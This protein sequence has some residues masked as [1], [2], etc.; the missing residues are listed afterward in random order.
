[1]AFVFF[2]TGTAQNN[3]LVDKDIIANSAVSPITTP[4]PWSMNKRLPIFAPG[5]I[6]IPVKKR[7]ICELSR[8]KNR[9]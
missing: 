6:S 1:M 8:P 7:V 3:T 9:I 2:Q 5:W 4:M